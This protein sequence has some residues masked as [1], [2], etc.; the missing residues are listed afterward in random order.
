MKWTLPVYCTILPIIISRGKHGKMLFKAGIAIQWCLNTKIIRNS[1]AQYH[2]NRVGAMSFQGIS[3][4]IIIMPGS[5]DRLVYL[6]K[7]QSLVRVYGSS[8]HVKPSPTNNLHFI[9]IAP[10]LPFQGNKLVEAHAARA[11]LAFQ[12]WSDCISCS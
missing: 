3:M 7:V 1:S 5:N 11:Q 12:S 10:S 4:F 8:R 6:R 9:F 2:S